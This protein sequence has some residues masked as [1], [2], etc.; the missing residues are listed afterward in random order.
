MAFKMNGW[1]AFKKDVKMYDGNGEEIT[2]DDSS[3]GKT[4]RDENGNKARDYTY[5]NKDG[6]KGVDVLYLSKPR[7]ESSWEGKT[8]TRPTPPIEQ[9]PLA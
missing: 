8:P 3:L 6:E 2:V 9:N 4:Y 7:G 1:S 5:T